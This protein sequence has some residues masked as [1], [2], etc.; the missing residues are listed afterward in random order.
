MQQR[1]NIIFERSATYQVTITVDNV[2]NIA[3]ATDWRLICA[4][5]NEPAF[6]VATIANGNFLPTAQSNSKILVVPASATAVMPL[7]NARYDF[8]I[9]WTGGVVYRYISNGLVQ[10]NPKAGT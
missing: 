6:L 9:V 7:G 2:P 10:V 4:Q 8:E 5:P 3:T 1:W